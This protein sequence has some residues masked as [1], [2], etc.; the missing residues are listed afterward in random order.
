MRHET[1]TLIEE[2][3]SLLPLNPKHDS[4][5]S[6]LSS[7]LYTP[8]GGEGIPDCYFC[9][10]W[11]RWDSHRIMLSNRLSFELAQKSYERLTSWNFFVTCIHPR[12]SEIATHLAL[13][14]TDPRTKEITHSI[15][16]DLMDACC[17]V[18]FADLVTPLFAVP[19]VLPVYRACRLPVGWD[20]PEID[21]HWAS[22][23]QELPKGKIIYV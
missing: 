14:I 7:S 4:P 9:G 22:S 13:N 10:Q 1:E 20:G 17:E 19:I 8:V 15:C 21:T 11:S 12:V 3:A 2:L 18:E 5:S 16:Q 23:R 6:A